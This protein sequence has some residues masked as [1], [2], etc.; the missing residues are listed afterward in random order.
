MIKHPAGI[1]EMLTGK[2]RKCLKSQTDNRSKHKQ[3]RT[4]SAF[5]R[6][7]N[8]NSEWNHEKAPAPHNLVSLTSMMF[9][10]KQITKI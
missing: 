7:P 10:R 1:F 5:Y 9:G 4:N 6:Y 2:I 8:F 3:E